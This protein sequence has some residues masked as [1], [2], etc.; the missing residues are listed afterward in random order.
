MVDFDPYRPPSADAAGPYH[1]GGEPL[2]TY[3]QVTLAT[4]FGTPVAGFIL[5]ALN[6]RR[7]GRPE[8]FGSMIGMGVVATIVVTAIVLA[9]PDGFPSM[10]LTLGY[11]IGMQQLARHW[12][13]AEVTERLSTGATKAS[14]WAAFGIG[15]ACFAVMILVGGTLGLMFPEWFL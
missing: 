9:L 7:L 13:G 1:A 8:K 15:M 3:Q 2:F 10:I 5:L 14:G 6:E 12:Q 4:F 11:L